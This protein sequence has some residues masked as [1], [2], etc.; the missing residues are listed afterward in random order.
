MELNVW[1][2]ISSQLK[3]TRLSNITLNVKNKNKKNFEKA[4]S[5]T[6]FQKPQLLSQ[7]VHPFLLLT[8]YLPR[9]LYLLLMFRAAIFMFHPFSGISHSWKFNLVPGSFP[10]RMEGKA[11]GSRLVEFDKR[12]LKHQTLQV[13]RTP[14]RCIF[15]AGQPLRMSRRFWAAV[16]DFKTR[17]FRL[18]P[19]VQKRERVKIVN[20]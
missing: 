14:T 13:P 10:W 20:I 1:E 18:K 12:E 8:L 7:S 9:Y 15:A 17:V 4:L 19:E 6:N 2:E 11:L 3:Q 5:S 16:T